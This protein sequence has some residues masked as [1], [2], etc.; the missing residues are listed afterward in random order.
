MKKPCTARSSPKN[1]LSGAYCSFF[2]ESIAAF[3]VFGGM[4]NL[5]VS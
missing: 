3:C 4:T 1:E 2:L 5:M